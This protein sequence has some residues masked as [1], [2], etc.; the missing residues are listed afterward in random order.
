MTCGVLSLGLWAVPDT[1]CGEASRSH[2][3]VR[4][5][6]MEGANSPQLTLDERLQRPKGRKLVGRYLC[7]NPGKRWKDLK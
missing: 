1:Y 6:T 5:V 4:E 2:L 7:N 3:G